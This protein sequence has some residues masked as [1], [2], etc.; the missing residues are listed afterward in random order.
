MVFLVCKMPINCENISFAFSQKPKP[1]YWSA[2]FVGPTF[3]N[4]NIFRLI[5]YED[6][7][8][9]FLLYKLPLIVCMSLSVKLCPRQI[10]SL[11][12]QP[13]KHRHSL[14]LRSPLTLKLVSTRPSENISIIKIPWVQLNGSNGLF[15]F[16]WLNSSVHGSSISSRLFISP[17][18]FFFS[19]PFYPFLSRSL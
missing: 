14:R 13:N 9:Q 3:Q 18:I 15:S 5:S 11:R 12:V 16:T 1:T 6:R 8:L 7:F 10:L 19:N 17:R 4:P 2:S